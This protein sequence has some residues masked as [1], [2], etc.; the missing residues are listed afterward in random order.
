MRQEFQSEGRGGPGDQTMIG[1]EIR[2]HAGRWADPAEF[3]RYVRSL[4]EATLEE[5]PR[6]G[7]FVPSKPTEESLTASTASSSGSGWRLPDG[8][9]GRSVP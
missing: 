2:E 3:A 5:S 4:R 7:G 1:R 9:Q 8:P 6:P